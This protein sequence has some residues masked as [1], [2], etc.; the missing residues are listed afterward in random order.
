MIM[1]NI[2]WGRRWEQLQT[3]ANESRRDSTKPSDSPS[4]SRHGHRV[5]V[6]SLLSLHHTEWVTGSHPELYSLG[7]L[8]EYDDYLCCAV[9]I[10]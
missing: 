7:R 1:E 6:S 8:L 2:S 3:I 9:I 4:R 10:I 5:L